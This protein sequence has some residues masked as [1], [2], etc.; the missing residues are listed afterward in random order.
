MHLLQKTNMKKAKPKIIKGYPEWV[1]NGFVNEVR[2]KKALWNAYKEM[3]KKATPSE[4]FEK[5][6]INGMTSRPAF[7]EWY[8]LDMETQKKIRDKWAKRYNLNKKQKDVLSFNLFLG[9]APR[10]L[11]G[12]THETK[13]KAKIPPEYVG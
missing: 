3:Y 2:I 1:H 8:F 10:S 7:Y 11:P 4:D 5:M 12:E 9:S 13:R 6:Y